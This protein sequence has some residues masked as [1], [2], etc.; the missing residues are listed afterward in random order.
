MGWIMQ[1]YVLVADKDKE[2]INELKYIL[3]EEDYKLDCTNRGERVVQKIEEKK[4]DLVILEREIE[5]INGIQ[6]CK[7]VREVSTIPIIVLSKVNDEMPMLLAFE[8]GADDYLVKPI[9]IIELKIRIKTIF[10]RI[11]YKVE[12]EPKHI[13][14]TNNFIINFLKRS[15]RVEG[16]DINLTGK[17]FDLFYV[18][19]SNPGKIF[20]R[21]EL[22][23]QVW[24]YEHYGDVRTVDVHIRRIRRKIEKSIE[25]QNYIMT[26]WGKGYYFNNIDSII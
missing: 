16:K 1:K 25:S 2:F 13:Y 5:G 23:D 15:I 8:H 24:G 9:N 7:L 6:L 11:S 17:E 12:S 4:Y 22:L 20:T 3:N 26:K 21:E 19:V 18:L 14:E 10:R